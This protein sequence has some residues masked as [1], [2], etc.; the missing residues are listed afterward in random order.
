VVDVW[1]G[2]KDS[3]GNPWLE[4]TTAPSFSTTKGALSTL[5]HILADQGKAGYDDAIASHWPEFGC[6]GK[7][8]ISI[9]QA[10]CHEA[11]LYHI[12]E[13]IRLP[14]EMLGWDHMKRLI[15]DA[16]PAHDPGD[17][18]GYHALTYGWLVGG[19][20]EAISRRPLQA[21][22][23]EELVAPLELDG[24]RLLGG[25]ACG[26]SLRCRAAP[27]IGYCSFPCIGAWAITV[28]SP[29]ERRRRMLSVTMGMAA[30]M[31]FVTPAEGWRGRSR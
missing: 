22:L 21:V 2:I 14:S 19:I 8:R 4:N 10:L 20:I 27:E 6:R 23:A 29:S 15:A 30:A 16:E 5:I 31:H 12:A 1:G 9:Q 17:A 28:C 7:D 18:H 11:G 26:K 13:M 25:H 24:V 3:A